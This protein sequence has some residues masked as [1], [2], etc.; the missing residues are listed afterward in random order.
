MQTQ[1]L[2]YTVDQVRIGNLDGDDVAQVETDEVDAV[3]GGVDA[4]V[5]QLDEDEEDDS[6]EEEEGGEEGE[7][8]AGAGRAF[9]LRFAG[10]GVGVVDEGVV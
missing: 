7:D 6:D 2:G 10:L 3:E 8:A 9:E 1:R 4:G 5:A